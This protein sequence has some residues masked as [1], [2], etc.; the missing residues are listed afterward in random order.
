MTRKFVFLNFALFALIFPIPKIHFVLTKTINLAASWLGKNKW[1]CV[2]NIVDAYDYIIV[3]RIRWIY[4]IDDL[5]FCFVMLCIIAMMKCKRSSR[6]GLFSI[7][8]V[9]FW[10]KNK[11]SFSHSYFQMER[12]PVDASSTRCRCRYS[13][14]DF[15][16]DCI[17]SY[18][19]R[20]NLQRRFGV[21]QRSHLILSIY[22]RSPTYTHSTYIIYPELKQPD[23]NNNNTLGSVQNRRCSKTGANW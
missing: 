19:Y 15:R 21:H 2:A 13:Y 8:I 11:I 1:Q 5:M 9:F 23:N 22:F 3:I 6:A 10:K 7:S 16:S 14:F 12:K 4:P 18:L 17:R 20:F